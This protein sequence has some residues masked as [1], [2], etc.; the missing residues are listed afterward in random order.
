MV[1]HEAWASRI[2]TLYQSQICPI[3]ACCRSMDHKRPVF[4]KNRNRKLDYFSLKFGVYIKNWT[5]LGWEVHLRIDSLLSKRF[6]SVC[7]ICG[8]RSKSCLDQFTRF[9]N[10]CYTH[11][12]SDVDSFFSLLLLLCTA[13]FLLLVSRFSPFFFFDFFSSRFPEDTIYWAINLETFES[14]SFHNKWSTIDF[15]TTCE[16]NEMK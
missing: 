13:C 9:I 8:A 6:N 15:Q 16:K 3:T 12:Y 14:N 11:C 5:I 4:T 1:V 2:R 10:T 7:I